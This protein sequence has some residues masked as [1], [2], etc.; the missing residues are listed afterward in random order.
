MHKKIIYILFIVCTINVSGQGKI[1]SPYSKFGVGDLI[2]NTSARNMGMGSVS[3]AV[4]SQ[5]YINCMNPAGVA[6]TDSLSFIFDFGING[7]Y[8]YYEIDNPPLSQI[9]SDLQ[10]SHLIIGFRITEWWAT[11]LGASPYSNVDYDIISHD[12]VIFDVKKNYRYAGRG[13]YN[14]IFWSNAFTPVENLNIG[15]NASYLFGIIDKNNA[16]NFDDDSGAYVN[17]LERT[18]TSVSDFMFDFGLQ[19]KLKINAANNLHLG[20]I[21]NYNSFIKGTKSVMKFNSLSLGGS[22][23]VDTL[24]NY[25]MTGT[26]T[27]PQKIGFGVC[28]EH[29]EKLLLAFDFTTQS[30]SDAKFF[31]VE[32][33]LNN[34]NSYNFGLEYKPIGKTGYAYRYSQAVSYRTGVHFTNTYLNLNENQEQINDFGISFGFG[35]PMERS[36]TS[37]NLSVQIGQR[38]TLRNDLIKENYVIF[39]LS[40][41]LTDRWFERRRFE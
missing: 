3:Y 5:G 31:D 37:F 35:L 12:S 24:D 10:I 7:G 9:K 33:S 32:Y 41:N 28:L 34:T 25:N 26:I 36:K 27:I 17:I 16:I 1:E 8:R 21:Y 2:N 23:I 11:R 14:K 40:F 38:G 29:N 18:R 6:Y 15:V 20:G 39:A 4:P 22:A 30:W 13:G 19:Y